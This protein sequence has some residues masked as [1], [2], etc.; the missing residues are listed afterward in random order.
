[1][2]SV[3]GGAGSRA[4]AKASPLSSFN[5][6]TFHPFLFTTPSAAP[7]PQKENANSSA[8]SQGRQPP[9]KSPSANDVRRSLLG[10]AS[11]LVGLATAF[12]GNAAPQAAPLSSVQSQSSASAQQQQ[13][14]QAKARSRSPAKTLENSGSDAGAAS[15]FV[16]FEHLFC[17]A[18]E[19][20]ARTYFDMRAG[21]TDLQKVRCHK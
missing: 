21:A 16:P 8:Q 11:P 9:V 12:G 7:S 2:P 15:D 10:A 4:S 17:V 6:Y 5:E 20:A 3:N 14:Q 19:A 18:L 13:Q 1:M